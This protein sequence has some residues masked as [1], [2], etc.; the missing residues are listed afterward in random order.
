MEEALKLVDELI[1]EHKV[2]KQKTQFAE[3]TLSDSSL[4]K[5]IEKARDTFISGKPDWSQNL[6]KLW[7]MLQSIDSSLEKHFYREET[8]LMPAVVRLNDQTLLDALETML[9]E[10]NDLR[11]RMAHSQRRVFELVSGTLAPNLWEVTYKDVQVYL[12]H[13]WKLL[14]THAENENHYLDDLRKKLKKAIK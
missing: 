7:E 11:D 12:T 4:L 3:N 14:T 5:D 2:I 1:T 6:Q 13:T 9:F 10:H 8:I